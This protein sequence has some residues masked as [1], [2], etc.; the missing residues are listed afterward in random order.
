M[1]ID[2]FLAELAFLG[3]RIGHSRIA[4]DQDASSQSSI[5]ASATDQTAAISAPCARHRVP[6]IGRKAFSCAKPHEH[7]AALLK[8]RR[9]A[10][11]A[12]LASRPV[13]AAVKRVLDLIAAK[14]TG[15]LA[16]Q[17]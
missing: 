16:L 5:R 15:K 1:T 14:T 6:M 17:P 11:R 10:C 9:D 7:P 8:L 2:I 3:D 12:G 13:S 4:Q